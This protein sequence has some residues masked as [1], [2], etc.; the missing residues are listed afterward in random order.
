MALCWVTQRMSRGRENGVLVEIKGNCALIG[1]CDAFGVEIEKSSDSG[2]E[3]FSIRGDGAADSG[4]EGPAGP[5]S[6]SGV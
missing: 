4:G 1:A 5:C 2:L 6:V 3:A